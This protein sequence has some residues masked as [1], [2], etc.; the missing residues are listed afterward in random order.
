MSSSFFY[1]AVIKQKLTFFLLINRRK[2]LCSR[3]FVRLAK[4]SLT[5][6]SSY[7]TPSYQ[8]DSNQSPSYYQPLEPPKTH[9]NIKP[10]RQ[11]TINKLKHL[12]APTFKNPNSKIATIFFIIL[13]Y[14][15]QTCPDWVNFPIRACS[16]C[17]TMP[18]TPTRKY[19]H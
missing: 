13:F 15:I 10:F 5:F 19:S 1:S 9:H 6:A 8:R 14:P 17:T 12:S 18:L 4:Y 11:K 3:L 2:S 16:A 7:T